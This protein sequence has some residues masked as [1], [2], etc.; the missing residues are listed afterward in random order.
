M[1]ATLLAQETTSTE[2]ADAATN[3]GKVK[4]LDSVSVNG[5]RGLAKTVTESAVPVDVISSEEIQSVGSNDTLDVLKTL[6][7]SFSVSRATNSTT[8]TFIRSVS[9]RGLSGDKTLLLVNG[10]R[11]HKSASVS[12]SGAGSQAADAAVIPSIAIKSVEVLRDGAAAQYGSDAIAGVINFQLKD[13]DHGGSFE[14]QIGQ[15]YAGDGDDYK[16]AG[17]MGFPLTDHGF[18]NISGEL[19]KND[20]A[21]RSTQYS[22]PGVFDPYEE[23][24]TNPAYAANVDLS[25]PLYRAGK[26]KSRAYRFFV[27][28]GI[29]IGDYGQVYAF[30]N[31]SWSQGWTD[32][33]Y[34]Y[35][36]HDQ[37]V[38]D[39]PVR[40]QDGSVWEFG[41]IFPAGFTPQFSGRVKD[42]SATFGYRD[43]LVQDDKEF[44]YDISG[45][46]G[47]DQIDYY[48]TNTVNPSLGPD[49]PR[50][51]HPYGFRNEEIS[52]NADTSYVLPV[53]WMADRLTIN[54][55][56][57][58]RREIFTIIPGDPASYAQGIY[59]TADPYDFCNDDGTPTA[60]APTGTTLDC[61]DPDDPVYNVLSVGSNG[62]PGFSPDDAGSW[63][64]N[65]HAAYLE[66]SGNITERWFLDLAGRYENYENFGGNSS[67][68]VATR[69]AFTDWLAVRG[70]VGTGFRA[71][72]TGLVN[73]KSVSILTVDGVMTETG[74]FP[75]SN[76]VALF[77]GAKP[78]KPEKSF[79]VSFGA[80]FTPADDINVTLDGYRMDIDDMIY[81]TSTISVTD[82][83]REQMQAAGV[84]GADTIS[85][86]YFFQNA[87]DAKVTGADLVGNWRKT[88][89]NHQVTDFSAS[90]N[91]NKYRI[92]KVNIVGLF[93]A[94]S[95]YNFENQPPKIKG[96]ITVRHDFG[97]IQ[98]MLRANIYG[99]YKYMRTTSPYPVQSYHSEVQFDTEVSWKMTGKVKLTIGASN[100]FDNYPQK[101]T[102]SSLTYGQVYR[103]GVVD[104]LG[105]YYYARVNVDF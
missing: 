46:Y 3:D 103:D 33:N 4:Q 81:A 86:V 57:E 43:S 13:A 52:L 99:P 80:V 17:N 105:G 5:L 22:N 74:L 25:E 90:L 98:A 95:I 27:N 88:W 94:R 11:R 50:K 97:P 14:S 79:N 72:T 8:G 92:D 91:Y 89:G 87:F 61:S 69:F 84:V 2:T 101:D 93:N 64:T 6:V 41:D 31:Y 42:Y 75:A 82:A 12:M 7:P 26:P 68:K 96:N 55:G 34:R 73:M 54:A 51:F 28:S 100:L 37:A 38:N 44:N 47:S 65:S 30:G 15:Y 53:S 78:L 32:A 24:A 66:A 40:L 58:F 63:G 102:I 1:P 36:G 23:A 9:L 62:F 70:S 48:M 18:I 83:I 59:A 60:N 20:R 49:S 10:K 85:S 104:W 39:T 77:L 71:P 19:S 29:D 35:P 56:A 45:R 21:V 16:V 67:Y 76:P